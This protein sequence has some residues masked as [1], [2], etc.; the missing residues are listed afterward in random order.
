MKTK[1]DLK[2]EYVRIFKEASGNV[3]PTS[4]KAYQKVDGVLDEITDSKYS[5]ELAESEGKESKAN[6]HR[7][8]IR[9]LNASLALVQ[10]AIRTEIGQA[11]SDIAITALKATAEFAASTLFKAALG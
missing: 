9:N 5:L 2:A 8:E 7:K 10:S 1:A 11:A 4:S 3:I 6:V